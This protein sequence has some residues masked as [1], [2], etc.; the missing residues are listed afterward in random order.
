MKI[1]F[2]RKKLFILLI[3]MF[4]LS[5]VKVSA[6]EDSEGIFL[7]FQSHDGVL[8]K[9][10]NK[11]N[12]ETITT[13]VNSIKLQK[14]QVNNN[15]HL[16]R[17]MKNNIEV[18]SLDVQNNMR[19]INTITCEE[20]SPN[21]IFL[22]DN[23]LVIIGTYVINNIDN[24]DETNRLVQEE[25][26]SK[27][28]S[29]Y[30]NYLCT[31][32]KIY[33]IENITNPQL[34]KETDILG[35]Y[36]GSIIKDNYLYIISNY[37]VNSVNIEKGSNIL[38]KVKDKSYN[39][40]LEN[41]EMNRIYG[42]DLFNNP[43][44]LNILSFNFEEIESEVDISSYMGLGE[45][46]YLSKD[47]L[48]TVI[49]VEN[50]CVVY[51]FYFE[52]GHI[53]SVNKAHIPG[54]MLSYT[55][56]DEYNGMLR[57][58]TKLDDENNTL[59]GI[60]LLD[61]NLNVKDVYFK[62]SKYESIKYF[63]FIDD[64]VFIEFENCWEKLYVLDLSNK[65]SIRELG[66]VECMSLDN[67]FYKN[68]TELICLGHENNEESNLVMNIYDLNNMFGEFKKDSVIIGNKAS[69]TQILSNSSNFLI[70]ED[71]KISAFPVSI[72]NSTEK[73]DIGESVFEGVYIYGV[74]DKGKLQ[75]KGEI[76]FFQHSNVETVCEY[77]VTNM[78][79]IGNIIYTVSD[80]MI[81]A[82]DI[83]DFKLINLAEI[84]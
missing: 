71:K 41:V 36:A 9:L 6:Y 77:A 42:V 63:R 45:N 66:Y 76:P 19:K 50:K 57:L 84:Q 61:D 39:M 2:K 68:G 78:F 47:N 1:V 17:I 10:R 35:S 32:I 52:N 59:G 72:M 31:K 75:F 27:I 33:N 29:P 51:K 65:E 40:N 30:C 12:N 22:K 44:Y 73:N 4:C 13:T 21:E 28:K 54:H 81:Y 58:A 69:Y 18:I 34:T 53:N 7:K 74:N 56:L 43:V 8:E 25:V 70:D 37:Y 60:Y 5:F 26:K 23:Y 3:I 62:D 48:Y 49:N 16:F 82:Y 38:P 46:I 15:N 24:K 67:F 80:K 14:D 55:S 64:K 11:N 79:N 20:F 83:N